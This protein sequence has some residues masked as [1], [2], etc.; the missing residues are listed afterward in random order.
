MSAITQHLN[1]IYDQYMNLING[2]MDLLMEYYD[3]L[4]SPSAENMK[5]FLKNLKNEKEKYEEKKDENDEKYQSPISVS[6]RGRRTPNLKVH[7]MNWIQ[8]KTNLFDNKLKYHLDNNTAYG[9]LM[10]YIQSGKSFA[11]MAICM[12]NALVKKQSTIW[13]LRNSVSDKQQAISG[14]QNTFG[15]NSANFTY[16][17]RYYRVTQGIQDTYLKCLDNSTKGNKNTK[18]IVD[19]LSPNSDSPSVIVALANPSQLQRLIDRLR[20]IENPCFNLVIDEFDNIATTDMKKVAIRVGKY[21]ILKEM[22]QTVI[23]CSATSFNIL[24]G[25]R[26]MTT[27]QIY[28]LTPR[29]EYKGIRHFQWKPLSDV[30]TYKNRA[31]ILENDA[32]MIPFVH[33]MSQ[34]PVYEAV[35]NKEQMFRHPVLVLN[36][37]SVYKGH[38]EEFVNIMS[39]Q[40][41]DWLVISYDGDD[42]IIYHRRLHSYHMEI[43]RVFDGETV[44]SVPVQNESNFPFYKYKNLQIGDVLEHFRKLDPHVEVFTHILIIAGKMADRGINYVSNNYGENIHRWHITDMYY[45]PSITTDCASLI[46]SMRPCGNYNDNLPVTI[47]TYPKV[48]RDIINAFN[49]QEDILTGIRDLEE[50]KEDE[51]KSISEFSCDDMVYCKKT[52]PVPLTKRLKIQKSKLRFMEDEK[53]VEVSSRLNRRQECLQQAESRSGIGQIVRYFL[54]NGPMEFSDF[55]RNCHHLFGIQF[56]KQMFKTGKYSKHGPFLTQTNSEVDLHEDYKVFNDR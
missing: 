30:S 23:G 32:D 52:F 56:H 39:N 24:F 34:K 41:R 8:S 29:P 13:I 38:H 16:G 20:S 1:C 43:R 36:K 4:T 22:A 31:S 54:S 46:Q 49:V 5:K 42:F 40:D 9:L 48:Q 2:D 45:K 6:Y 53:K 17:W 19:A 27:D 55:Q 25:D 51:L 18:R 35:D 47:Y 14:I 50:L 11:Q 28:N 37:S 12:Y 10:G 21:N 15:E 33:E 7:V 26:V 44:E 3:V